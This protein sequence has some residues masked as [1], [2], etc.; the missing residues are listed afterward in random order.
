MYFGE[1]WSGGGWYYYRIA[2]KLAYVKVVNYWNTTEILAYTDGSSTLYVKA[3]RPLGIAAVYVFDGVS[4]TR[5]PPPP[6]PPPCT[7]IRANPVCRSPDAEGKV[8]TTSPLYYEVPCGTP[9]DGSRTIT[10]YTTDPTKCDGFI[11]TSY[12][13]VTTDQVTPCPKNGREI[14]CTLTSPDQFVIWDCDH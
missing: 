9:S 8:T 2:Y 6:P 12:G 13:R 11:S 1:P 10:G 14:S 7:E 4:E 3:D 5:P